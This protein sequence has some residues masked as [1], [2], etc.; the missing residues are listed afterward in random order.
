[1]KLLLAALVAITAATGALAADDRCAVPAEL[2]GDPPPL[3]RVHAALAQ[4]RPLTVVAVGGASTL[5]TAAG[6]PEAAFPARLEAVLRER[7]PGIEI[8]VVN[9]GRPREVT[10]TMVDRLTAHLLE[11]RPQLVIWETG[12]MDAVQRTDLAEFDHALHY[13]IALARARGADVMLMDFQ[14][15][16]GA[17][18]VIDFQPYFERLYGAADI[19]DVPVFQRYDMMRHWSESGVLNLAETQRDKLQTLAAT[20]YD[21]IG[22]RLADVIERAAR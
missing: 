13:G 20:L 22:K 16:R 9:A 15:G 18:A 21:C 14:Y 10:R 5:G 11:T 3:L 1:M 17:S 2:M 12:I 7:Y 8:K 6:S 19:D 4:R